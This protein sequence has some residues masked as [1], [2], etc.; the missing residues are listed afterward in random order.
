MTVVE[1]V[2]PAE[3]FDIN[4]FFLAQGF[5]VELR[6]RGR[7]K[8]RVTLSETLSPAQK[9]TVENALD[10]ERKKVTWT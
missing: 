1:F 8:V 7:S 9:T 5:T 3:D 10:A 6:E 2:L 4:A